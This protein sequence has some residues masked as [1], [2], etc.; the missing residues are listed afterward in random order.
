MSDAT[1]PYGWIVEHVAFINRLQEL[2]PWEH[3]RRILKLR[4]SFVRNGCPELANAFQGYDV[5]LPPHPDSEKSALIAILDDF[6]RHYPTRTATGETPDPQLPTDQ[7]D[8]L[9][10]LKSRATQ[11]A[12]DRLGHLDAPPM[13]PRIN[14]RDKYCYD[15][16]TK[17]DT[18]AK[19]KEA[20]NRRKK[21]EPLYTEPG[22]SQAAKRY[23]K[24][25][26]KK[27][28]IPRA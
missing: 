11:A 14:A 18:L 1:E 27:W 8:E 19:I 17:G 24:K 20:V 7:L 25:H 12:S 9:N 26:G 3:Q 10:R 23:A 21:W 16:M 5:E 2:R 4:M 28:P 13:R 6:H 22:V 15:R